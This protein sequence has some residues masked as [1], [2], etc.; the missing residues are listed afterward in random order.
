VASFKAEV[1]RLV[2]ANQVL[3]L[4]GATGCGKTTQVPQFLLEDAIASGR[5]GRCRILCTQPR[6]IAAIS[7]AQRV[8]SERQE[9]LGVA[10]GLVGYQIRGE[11]R[12][13]AGTALLFTTTG[14]LLRR[15]TH[16]GLGH[17]THLVVDEVHER[18]VDTD[19]LLAVLRRV[20]PQRPDVKV[21]L[22]SA[23]M[24]AA[25]FAAYF[26]GLDAPP[27][28]ARAPAPASGAQRRLAPAASPAPVPV[29]EVPGFVHPV[30]EVY[31]EEVLAMTGYV[32][33]LRDS[34][35]ILYLL[36]HYRPPPRGS[37]GT[38]R[39]GV[40]ALKRPASRGARHALHASEPRFWRRSRARVAR[41]AAAARAVAQ[42]ARWILATS[43]AGSS[44]AA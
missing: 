26:E 40:Q 28:P 16:S 19:F 15:L 34:L 38:N 18:N 21:V 43:A 37:A 9:P 17:V 42:R 32:P 2:A 1:L 39:E 22:M 24:D 20:L 13:H 14:V 31:L 5:G 35:R 7:V 41:G 8:A 10:G 27:G 30:R 29:I 33:F 4:S 11:R 36:S 6:R 23:T 44:G 25:A 3:L 12:A